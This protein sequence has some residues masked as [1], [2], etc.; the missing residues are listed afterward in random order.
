[1]KIKSAFKKKRY[2]LPPGSLV[3]S[4]LDRTGEKVE[5][6]ILEFNNDKIID[7]VAQ[8]AQ[9][10]V[11]CIDTEYTSWIGFTGVHEVKKVKEVCQ[12]LGIHDLTIED[13][14]STHQRPK[15]EINDGYVFATL[16]SIEY[17]S[18]KETFEREQISLILLKG[19]VI[20]FQERKS[21][22]L[23]D[24]VQRVKKGKGRIRRMGTDYL[25]Y[26]ILDSII[27]RYFL[28]NDHLQS[29]LEE[30]EDLSLGDT[31]KEFIKEIQWLKKELLFIRRAVH[32]VKDIINTLI[33]DETP[34]IGK[35]TEIYL[36][37]A[38]DHCTQVQEG[39]ENIRDI[40]DGLRDTYNSKMSNKMNE[41]MKYLAVFTSIFTPL[42]F[43]AGIYGMNFK[44]MPELE[45][46][47]G[48]HVLWVIMIIIGL[49]L[50]IIFKRKKW[51]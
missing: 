46:E 16:K 25:F 29:E 31:D 32:P 33:R 48:Y 30:L 37:D 35:E 44:N 12:K 38:Y 39:V 41:I 14:L 45:M 50:F 51:L 27:D 8:D 4:G 1:M 22:A 34:L 49:T 18:E 3:Y 19:I 9:R 5:V 43:I 10:C 42:S 11:S 6:K 40:L 47:Y 7:E 21:D 36:R 17:H 23:N 24:V 2:G 13:I 28:V 20:S 26:A 15:V